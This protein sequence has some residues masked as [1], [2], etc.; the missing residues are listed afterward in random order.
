MKDCFTVAGTELMYEGKVVGD[1]RGLTF[2]SG[3]KVGEWKEEFDRIHPLAPLPGADVVFVSRDTVVGI[4]RK[5]WPDLISSR[6]S[7]RLS[8]Q[9]R[10]MLGCYDVVML[11]IEFAEMERRSGHAPPVR[12]PWQRK[13][14]VMYDDLSTALLDWQDQ[15]VRV[16]FTTGPGHTARYARALKVKYDS[17]RAG[18]LTRTMRPAILAGGKGLE[19]LTSV[20]GIGPKLAQKL[21]ANHG[22]LFGVYSHYVGWKMSSLAGK[23]GKSLA[24]KMLNGIGRTV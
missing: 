5:A 23:D 10:R 9:L 14:V 20:P 1:C 2:A 12:K 22:S 8:D 17:G 13:E 18:E 3:D 11:V 7:G 6:F 24:K 16:V 19:G 4:E 15:G 21:V